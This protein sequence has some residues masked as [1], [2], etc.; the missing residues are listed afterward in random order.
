MG[1]KAKY[2]SIYSSTSMLD[3]K[4]I[5]TTCPSEA[6]HHFSKST[7]SLIK[8]LKKSHQNSTESSIDFKIQAVT[9]GDTC[10]DLP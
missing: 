4:S 7:H 6:I 9:S 5:T 1:T 3:S 2:L 8:Q 10:I